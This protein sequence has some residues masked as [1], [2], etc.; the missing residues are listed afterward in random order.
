MHN[1]HTTLGSPV[2][3]PSF[4]STHFNDPSSPMKRKM[5]THQS[6]TGYSPCLASACPSSII[7]YLWTLHIPMLNSSW[8]TYSELTI[9][10][11][12]LAFN[13]LSAW[14]TLS[15]FSTCKYP[16]HFSCHF[17]LRS[18]IFSPPQIS[19]HSFLWMP[20][21]FVY[22]RSNMC[23]IWSFISIIGSFDWS[24]TRW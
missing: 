11:Y 1:L 24:Y 18:R 5:H 16:I 13:H 9:L 17:L 14:Y 23:N 6:N 8:H 19:E 10:A 7:S 15:P 3:L 21:Y 12:Y 2:T 4:N 20:L 22:T